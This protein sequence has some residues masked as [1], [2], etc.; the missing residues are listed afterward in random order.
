MYT[1]QTSLDC[2]AEVL[3]WARERELLP[4]TVQL[5]LDHC[6]N[7]QSTSTTAS[8]I[9]FDSPVQEGIPKL[10]FFPLHHHLICFS[11]HL[12]SLYV[13]CLEKASTDLTCSLINCNRQRLKK[14][15]AAVA[16]GDIFGKLDTPAIYELDLFCL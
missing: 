13:D 4:I 5:A 7:A 14:R 9:S 6:I 3:T 10:H 8:N 2:S 15:E 11:F 16:D 12:S 1:D